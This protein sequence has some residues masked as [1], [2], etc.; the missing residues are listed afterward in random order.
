MS[1]FEYV[2]NSANGHDAQDVLQNKL[3]AL[4]QGGDLSIVVKTY[5]AGDPSAKNAGQFYAPFM[6]QFNNGARWVVFSTTSCRTDRIKGQ[7]WDADNLKRLDARIEKAVLTYPDDTPSKER[8]A[9]QKQQQKY[10]TGLEISRLDDIVPHEVLVSQITQRALDI[11]QEKEE[12]ERAIEDARLAEEGAARK[13][14][15]AA[16]REM[17]QAATTPAFAPRVAAANETEEGRSYDFNGRAF[18]KDIAEMLNNQTY[19]AR[20]KNGEAVGPDR[21][22]GCFAKM[23]TAFGLNPMQ[24]S[25]IEATAEKEDIGLLPSGGQPKTD[26]WA[27]FILTTGEQKEYTISCKRTTRD[28]VSVHQYTADTFADV[29][30]PGNKSLRALLNVFQFYANARDMPEADRVALESALHPLLPRL[31]KWVLGGFG[32]ES[33]SPIQYANFLVVYNPCDEYFAVHS[34]EDYT[35]MLLKRPALAFGTPFGWTYAS[36]QRQKSIQLKL[37]IIRN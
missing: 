28:M 27:K 16:V 34:V 37:P 29:L 35:Q 30:D 23:V 15:E 3:L 33:D 18:E 4:R 8:L 13:A 36:K 14:A 9:F 7:Q 6:I 1:R 26:V 22:Y 17:A 12:Q 10:E 25:R 31:C 11:F 19:L 32:A 21:K 2:S 24:V 20:M 5:R